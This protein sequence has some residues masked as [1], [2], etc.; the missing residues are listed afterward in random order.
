[1]QLLVS[2]DAW[3]TGAPRAHRAQELPPALCRE[4]MHQTNA[5]VYYGSFHH[6]EVDALPELVGDGARQVPTKRVLATRAGIPEF[7]PWISLLV[8]V[9]GGGIA[10]NS[11]GISMLN[12]EMNLTCSR[13]LSIQ[14]TC[15]LMVRRYRIG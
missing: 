2:L 7:K 14:S 3:R 5:A 15:Q 4:L 12:G 8:A 1:M 9:T 6:V 13:F 10:C 11:R